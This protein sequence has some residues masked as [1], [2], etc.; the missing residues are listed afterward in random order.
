MAYA[1]DVV[2]FAE[3]TQQRKEV[4]RILKKYFARN[5]MTPNIDKTK[6]MT[7]SRGRLSKEEWSWNKTTKEAFEEVF[8]IYIHQ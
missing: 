7:F 2:I 5:D 3:D 6:I 8:R 4:I 1:D